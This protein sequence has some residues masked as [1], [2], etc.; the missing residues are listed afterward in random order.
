MRSL[1][2]FKR[3]PKP[4]LAP[5]SGGSFVSRLLSRAAPGRLPAAAAPV[6]AT[7]AGGLVLVAAFAMFLGREAENATPQTA[8]LAGEQAQ[9]PETTPAASQDEPQAAEPAAEAIG[10]SSERAMPAAAAAIELGA[11][12]RNGEP[13]AGA[14]SPASGDPAIESYPARTASI[15]PAVPDIGAR[16]AGGVPVAE[17]D[18][19]IAVLEAIQRREVEEDLA[20]PTDEET[21]SIGPAASGPMRAATT[22][23]YV[24]MRAAPEDD[25]EVLLVVPA[26]AEIEVEADCNW[27]AVVY[28]GRSG[29]IYKTFISYA[30]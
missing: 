25:A 20:T 12:P 13:G 26:L 17:T 22:T 14:A 27:C 3:A 30:D 7:L 16:P 4:F 23:R 21:A 19:E 2:K 10:A 24:N 15:L 8:I 18:D 28:D 9:A 29:F 6:A 1:L 5:L 11:L